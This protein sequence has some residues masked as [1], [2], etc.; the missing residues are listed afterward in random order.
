MSTSS[1][2]LFSHCPLCQSEYKT[3][4]SLKHVDVVKCTNPKCQFLFA[5]TQPSDQDL[6][7][8]YNDYYYESESVDTSKAIKPNSDEEKFIQHIQ[9]LKHKLD[10][11]K[12]TILDYG[13]GVGNFMTAAR[14]E[15]AKEVLG[16]ELNP[17]ARKTAE[18]RGFTVTE[19]FSEHT[20]KNIDLVYMNDVIEHLRDPVESLAQ[21]KEKLSD[22]GMVFIV[23]LNVGGLKARLMK[24][25]WDLITDPTHFY[26]YD[27]LSLH[28][29]ILKA[30]YQHSSFENFFVKFGHH[31]ILRSLSQ[32]LLVKCELDTGL[33]VLAY[34]NKP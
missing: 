3:H 26:F 28:N 30:G 34:K 17:R 4:Y 6:E 33:K 13:C 15:G 14:K 22:R 21:I 8:I 29:S 10:F 27:K 23:T 32:R 5:K 11:S 1:S 24:E 20:H 7:K 16:V 18:S 2:V 25:K 12:S 31:N 9:F 19:T